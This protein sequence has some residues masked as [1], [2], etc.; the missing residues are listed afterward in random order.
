MGPV[1]SDSYRP[2]RYVGV[3]GIWETC[4]SRPAVRPGTSSL[5]SAA[6]C[7]RACPRRTK[8]PI[9]MRGTRTR[10]CSC[11][12]RWLPRLPLLRGSTRRPARP[13]RTRRARTARRHAGRRRPRRCA[14]AGH[15]PAARVP[16]AC[17]FRPRARDRCRVPWFVDSE[18][19]RCAVAFLLDHT[20]RGDLTLAVRQECNHAW[21]A[22]LANNTALQD[23]LQEHG[24]TL[25]EA[26]RIQGPHPRVEFGPGGSRS[27]L[28]APRPARP[29]CTRRRRSATP[30]RSR[31]ATGPARPSSSRAASARP[32]ATTSAAT[33]AARLRSAASRS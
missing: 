29:G 28:P 5:P 4:G 6:R 22:G 31:S 20:G 13:L 8:G 17:R 7:R 11:L 10:C 21:I 26:A 1:T 2:S 27:A 18:G 30:G 9:P 33:A 16:R 32:D 23:W 19:R 3:T 15:R 25:A 14:A 24:L 12:L